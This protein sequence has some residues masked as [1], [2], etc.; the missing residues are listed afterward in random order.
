MLT[1]PFELLAEAR[2][3]VGAVQQALSLQQ[4]YWLTR[5]ATDSVIQGADMGSLADGLAA[6]AQVGTNSNGSH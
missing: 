4:A 3:Q 1:G 6:P 5:I 2:A